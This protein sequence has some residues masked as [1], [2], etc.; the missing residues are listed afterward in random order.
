MTACLTEAARESDTA[1]MR[2]LLSN[3]DGIHAEGLYTLRTA[4]A[5]LG[6]VRIVA[7]SD[8]QSAVGHAITVFD[9]IK[10]RETDRDGQP[11]G[12]AV[13]GTPA[14][15]IK[16]AVCGLE[17]PK[18]DLVL[19]GI[20]LGD[21]TGISVL[22][23]GTVSAATE[24]AILGLPAVAFSLCTFRHPRWDTAALAARH[25]VEKVLEYGLPPDTLL[26]V[27][28]PNVA[29][30]ELQGYRLVEVGRSRW[31]EHFHRREDPRGAAYYWLDGELDRLDSR[32]ETDI[33]LIRHGVVTLTPIGLDMTAHRE[34]A[35]MR[36][37]W[38]L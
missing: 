19:S 26:N 18:P 9:P 2:F 24:A 28:I 12:L 27:N 8:E 22:Y 20:N 30:E 21:N 17:E 7:P 31:R 15:C 33:R 11:Y 4:V 35:A 34:L 25:V 13:G 10:T 36:Q 32:P 29:P 5:P 6:E 3:D 38:D 37:S 23:S 1:A 16:L 14:D